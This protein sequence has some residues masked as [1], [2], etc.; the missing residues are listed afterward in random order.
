MAFTDLAQL[1]VEHWGNF[2]R[3][4]IFNS[5]VE[6]FQVIS[7][8]GTTLYGFHCFMKF[9]PAV[10]SVVI[11][12]FRSVSEILEHELLGAAG[13]PGLGGDRGR[14]E[15]HGLGEAVGVSDKRREVALPRGLVGLGLGLRRPDSP[16]LRCFPSAPPGAAQP[17]PDPARPEPVPQA[18]GA[19]QTP[20]R[21][22]PELAGAAVRVEPA[23]AEDPAGPGTGAPTRRPRVGGRESQ[24]SPRPSSARA[25]RHSGLLKAFCILNFYI[26]FF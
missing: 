13:G 14:G 3:T 1:L 6:L 2:V 11:R 8:G 5:L 7:D 9:L 25:R 18:S 26:C 16:S 12:Q 15:G 4:K 24:R 20:T 19:R 22:S 21:H 23:T 17:P 10:L